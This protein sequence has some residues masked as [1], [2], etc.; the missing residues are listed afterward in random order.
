MVQY[1]YPV[2]GSVPPSAAQ[3]RDK[4]LVICNLVGN[5]G[6]GQFIVEHNWNLSAAELASGF[7]LVSI[8]F[9]DEEPLP[10]TWSILGRNANVVVVLLEPA[11]FG[12]GRKLTV[13]RPHSMVR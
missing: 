3:S 2:S 4:N 11:F 1:L 12:P 8:E 7:P 13:S 10:N 9:Q 5:G 6:T